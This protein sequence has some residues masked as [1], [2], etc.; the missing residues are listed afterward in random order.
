MGSAGNNRVHSRPA[1]NHLPG[2]ETSC[3][4]PLQNRLCSDNIVDELLAKQ[5]I[6]EA[7]ISPNS[8]ISQLFLVKKK[9]GGQR[10]VVNLKA[11]NNFV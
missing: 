4:A 10:P 3:A 5:A 11:L 2:K 7:L 9:G 1:P 6:R 8:F